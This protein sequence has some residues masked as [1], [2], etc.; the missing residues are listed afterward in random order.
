MVSK[1]GLV[2]VMLINVTI[3]AALKTKMVHFPLAMSFQNEAE[4]GK[5]RSR[6][7]FSVH[8]PVLRFPKKKNVHGMVI[9]RVIVTKT[10]LILY[11]AA[12][13]CVIF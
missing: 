11:V 4:N 1:F 12:T 10:Q 2:D 9:N 3:S 7:V 6:H 5:L 8:T 13:R